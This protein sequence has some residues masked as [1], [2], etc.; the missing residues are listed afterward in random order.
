MVLS[1]FQKIVGNMSKLTL[2]KLC[3]IEKIEFPDFY[4]FDLN[5]RL[6]MDIRSFSANLEDNVNN[7]VTILVIMNDL[8]F[9]FL[10]TIFEMI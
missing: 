6:S 9:K 10:G 3:R 1:H 5:T 8:I 4:D 7:S 2:K